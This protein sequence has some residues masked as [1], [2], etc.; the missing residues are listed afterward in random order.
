M[1]FASILSGPTE[2]TSPIKQPSLPEALPGPATTITPAPPTLAPVPARRRLTPPP[3]THALP[4]TSQLKVKEPEPISPAALPRL[5]K[6]PSAEKRRRNVEQEPKSAEALP[7]ASTHGAFEPTKAARV[8]NRKT[9]TERDA[10]AINKIIAEIDN[11]DKSDV[12]SPGFE[13]EYGRYMVKSKKRALDA[14]KAEGIRRKVGLYFTSF[15]I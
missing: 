1:S 6:K 12:E 13:V 2:E 10:E 4:P 14:E 15:H 11:A 5:E 3:V 9:L 7:V 8:S